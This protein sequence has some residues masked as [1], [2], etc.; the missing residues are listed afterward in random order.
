MIK[1]KKESDLNIHFDQID[2]NENRYRKSLPK[3][4]EFIKP[5]G[6]AVDDPSYINIDGYFISSLLCIN[7][8]KHSFRVGKRA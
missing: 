8:H 6:I 4:L 7:S 5:S 3:Y 1:K 2:Q